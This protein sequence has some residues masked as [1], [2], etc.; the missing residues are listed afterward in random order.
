MTGTYLPVLPA[1]TTFIITFMTRVCSSNI[2][3]QE[4]AC[5]KSPPIVRLKTHDLKRMKPR[6]IWSK[7]P[8]NTLSDALW[9]L[10]CFF[11]GVINLCLRRPRGATRHYR[12]LC[13]PCSRC[14]F[15]QLKAPLREQVS[16][17][18]CSL[19]PYRKPHPWCLL[20]SNVTLS[21]ASCQHYSTHESCPT[22]QV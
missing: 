3:L 4:H 16:P 7:I 18:S 21:H 14:L 15:T 8:V 1:H 2:C 11:C 6:T 19:N 17:C 13:V 12:D 22:R 9:H 10:K 5:V 20:M